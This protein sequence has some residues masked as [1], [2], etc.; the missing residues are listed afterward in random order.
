MA[1]NHLNNLERAMNIAYENKDLE[2][3]KIMAQEIEA[4]TSSKEKSLGGFAENVGEDA[5]N[6]GSAIGDM[7][8]N[9]LDTTGAIADLPVTAATNLLPKSLVDNLFSYENDPNSFQYK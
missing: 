8:A 1:D 6:V 2:K 3:A 5:V 9:P 7:V 4:Y